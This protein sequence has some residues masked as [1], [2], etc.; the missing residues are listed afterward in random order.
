MFLGYKSIIETTLS[1]SK[2][3]KKDHLAAALYYKDKAGNEEIVQKGTDYS[4]YQL[5]RNY[6]K[7]SSKTYFTTQLHCDFLNSPRLLIPGC[8]LRYFFLLLLFTF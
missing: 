8:N 2:D 4:G 7:K 1:F 6:V 5:R 3:A